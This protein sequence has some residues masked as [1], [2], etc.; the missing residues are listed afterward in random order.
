MSNPLGVYRVLEKAPLS[1]DQ[2]VGL[3]RAAGEPTRLRL[4][5]LL[6][7]R[8][9]TVSARVGKPAPL[10]GVTFSK[11]MKAN[12]NASHVLSSMMTS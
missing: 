5:M 11:V 1:L 2:T 12:G 4:L 8:D 10:A 7:Q 6:A 3:L 9:L